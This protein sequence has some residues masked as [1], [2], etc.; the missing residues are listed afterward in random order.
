MIH[1]FKSNTPSS[2]RTRATR[3][4]IDAVKLKAAAERQ[5][6]HANVRLRNL[7]STERNRAN[8]SVSTLLTI[9]KLPEVQT[10]SQNQMSLEI[11]KKISYYLSQY[12][13]LK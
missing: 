12:W 9:S 5:M 8:R 4:M 1:T 13:C 10:S 3:N 11:F 6:Q 7:S 2:Q